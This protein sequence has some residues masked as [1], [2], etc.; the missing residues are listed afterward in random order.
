MSH[1][2]E[3]DSTPELSP[4][5]TN[6][7][8]VEGIGFLSNRNN[9]EVDDDDPFLKRRFVNLGRSSGFLCAACGYLLI[10]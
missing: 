7:D 5:A 1:T 9:D 8:S 4:S 6:D 10:T 2:A 3:P